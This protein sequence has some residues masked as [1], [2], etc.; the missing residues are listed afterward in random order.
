MIDGAGRFLKESKR[1]FPFPW[2]AFCRLSG[3]SYLFPQSKIFSSYYLGFL[4]EYETSEVE[5]LSGAF[6][7]VR[8]KILDEIGWFDEQFFMYSE[9]IDLSYRI[10][11][12]GY[13]NYY[14]ASS[15]IIHFKGEST[16]K[17]AGY[18][19]LFYRAM[20]QFIKK[21]FG[22]GFLVALLEAS[23]WMRSKLSAFSLLFV[24]NV[25]PSGKN[26]QT[27]IKGDPASV[28]WVKERVPM[29]GRELAPRQEDAGELIFCEG[30]SFSFK[31]IIDEIQKIMP[32]MSIKI[33][34]VG[35][36][37]LVGSVSEKTLGETI[38]L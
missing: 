30:E 28:T 10:R 34:A 20:V 21:H 18:V 24:E 25:Q 11:Q 15:T 38:A 36:A 33:H 19:R 37:S 26:I 16:K 35:S 17:D 32:P 6:L 3:L 23:I 5:V 13:K 31:D 8:K 9:D 2:A 4:P 22:S 12:A 7:F 29:T 1:G 14:L 27:Y